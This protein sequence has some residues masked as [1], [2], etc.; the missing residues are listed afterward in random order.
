MTTSA[1][2]V[3]DSALKLSNEDRAAV[4]DQLLDSFDPAP[5]DNDLQ[6]DEE[7]LAE[8]DRRA[9]ELRADPTGGIPWGEVKNMQ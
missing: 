5:G 2:A 7:L 6:A 8:L 1:K 9:T 3:L 4:A